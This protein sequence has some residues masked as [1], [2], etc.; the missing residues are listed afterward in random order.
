MSMSDCRHL[1]R[2]EQA[3]L[4]VLLSG[5]IMQS[6]M[7]QSWSHTCSMRSGHKGHVQ[8]HVHIHNMHIYIHAWN[9]NE[10]VARALPCDVE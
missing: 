3:D 2:P 4:S 9:T 8:I 7:T 5:K 1:Q 6:D 10:F